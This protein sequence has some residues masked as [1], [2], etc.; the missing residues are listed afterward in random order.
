[1]TLA[2]VLIFSFL[3]DINIVVFWVLTG[4]SFLVVMFLIGC[5]IYMPQ[6]VLKRFFPFYLPV[7]VVLLIMLLQLLMNWAPLPLNRSSLI[8]NI[9]G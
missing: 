9:Y 8:V 3:S 5:K 6:D 7:L 1:M 4:V 2:L